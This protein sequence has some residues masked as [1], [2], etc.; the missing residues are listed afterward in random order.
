MKNIK[1]LEDTKPIEEKE[2]KEA[3]VTSEAS[4]AEYELNDET[5]TNCSIEGIIEVKLTIS[6]RQRHPRWFSDSDKT[7]N[8]FDGWKEITTLTTILFKIPTL[9]KKRIVVLP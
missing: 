7:R 6:W 5:H 9:V 3:T 1:S 4:V 2:W 8:L